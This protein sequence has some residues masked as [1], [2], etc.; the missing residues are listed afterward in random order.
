MSVLRF[1]S[2]LLILHLSYAIYLDIDSAIMTG[3]ET[4]PH[5]YPFAIAI[6]STRT[7]PLRQMRQCGGSLISRVAVLTSAYCVSGIVDTTLFLGA[8]TIDDPL[9]QYQLKITLTPSSVR[10]HPSYI[11]NQHTNDIAIVRIP[12]PIGFFNHAI[13]IV[14]LPSNAGELFEN[15]PAITMGY[16]ADSWFTDNLNRLMSANVETQANSECTT[17]ALQSTQMCTTG[18]GVCAGDD[19]GPL[20]ISRNGQYMQVGIIQV[21]NQGGAL[22][23]CRLG[24]LIYTRVNSFLDWIEANM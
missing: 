1:F 22:G 2:I 7:G 11:A 17:F 10:I 3:D 4:Q 14:F 6:R 8:H 16:G 9:E 20:V 15:E 19:G 13:N 18:T 5:Q 23:S 12:T 21:I 24:T